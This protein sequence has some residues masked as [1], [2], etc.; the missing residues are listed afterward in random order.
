[1]TRAVWVRV[2]MAMLFPVGAAQSQDAIG[3]PP[4]LNVDDRVSGF[5]QLWS[6]AKTN[7]VFEE[8]RQ[9]LDWNALLAEYLPLVRAEQSTRDY[10][11]VLTR[12]IAGLHD[13]HT[14]VAMP[15]FDFA[16]PIV[17]KH[18]PPLVVQH[19]EGKATIVDLVESD[20][21]R[22]A[23]VTR[24]ME[25]THI[26]GRPVSAV[27]QDLDPYLCVSTPQARDAWVYPVLLDGPAGSRVALGVRD[28]QG[29][30][31]AITL[32]REP[33]TPA[34]AALL[35]KPALAS[36][37]EEQRGPKGGPYPWQSRP[38]RE[39]RD[40]PDGILYVPVDSFFS[41]L[42]K[43]VVAQYD[44]LADRLAAAKALILD[45]RENGGG[46]SENADAIVSRLT[47]KP[48]LGSRWKT[49]R[50][51]GAWA[52][53][54][55]KDDWFE[56]GVKTIQP[57]EGQRPFLGPVVV[58]V[59]PRTLSAAEDFLIP[60]HVSHRAILVGQRTAGSTGQ[61]LVIMLPGGGGAAICT[62]WDS[63]PDGRE[64]VGVGID[65]DVEVYPT[66]AEVA[67]GLW[68]GGKDPVLERGV[69]VLRE[70]LRG[71]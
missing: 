12:F 3:T 1:M 10:Y 8:K 31:R 15:G 37:V 60:L 33:I 69:A 17:P 41:N 61:P 56:G 32:L 18:A 29:E 14:L 53:W 7:F 46:N 68:S 11:R 66:Q 28:P 39:P 59:G 43:A 16:V 23:R 44:S 70:K 26:D 40:L 25:I 45:L 36:L 62:K 64:F 2:L 19:V 57:V 6:A 55:Q 5:V 9:G 67:A 21:V 24:G 65:P 47:D 51:L 48:L 52:A 49:R 38:K 34:F 4:P 71:R 30:V 22:R 42:P 13:A 58:L 35:P 50:H 20:E 63:Y 54:G 27:L